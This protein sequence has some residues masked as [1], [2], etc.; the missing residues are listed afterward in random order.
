M[1]SNANKQKKPV[2][3]TSENF[4]KKLPN[5]AEVAPQSAISYQLDDFNYHFNFQNIQFQVKLCM[6]TD[7]KATKEFPALIL[8][9][10]EEGGYKLD[11]KL[12]F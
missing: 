12:Q 3:F 10:I 9:L 2:L 6:N 7:E 11:Q 1:L 5:S 8:K 4:K